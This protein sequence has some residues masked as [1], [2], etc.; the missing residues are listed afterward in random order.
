MAQFNLTTHCFDKYGKMIYNFYQPNI[1]ISDIRI[2]SC[3]TNLP[4]GNYYIQFDYFHAP[5]EILF[6]IPYE[7]NIEI[8]F[9]GFSDRIRINPILNRVNINNLKMTLE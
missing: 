6:W 1:I 8:Q 9:L 2:N 7:G 3:L 4:K 5:N